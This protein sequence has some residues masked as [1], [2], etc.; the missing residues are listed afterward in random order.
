M[1]LFKSFQYN[2]IVYELDCIFELDKR[3]T[4]I[5]IEIY[6]HRD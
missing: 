1:L 5:Y 3:Q 6:V 2:F 4:K